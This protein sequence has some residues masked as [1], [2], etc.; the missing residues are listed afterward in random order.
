MTPQLPILSPVIYY[1]C[2]PFL[3]LETYLALS[4]STLFLRHTACRSQSRWKCGN[5][6]TQVTSPL[7]ISIVSNG[8]TRN[9][10]SPGSPRLPPLDLA[11]H[12]IA[13]LRVPWRR[14]RI[15]HLIV[16]LLPLLWIPPCIHLSQAVLGQFPLLLAHPTSALR[17]LY[18]LYYAA[19]LRTLRMME[20]GRLSQSFNRTLIKHSYRAKVR[21]YS[22]ARGPA[23]HDMQMHIIMMA[24]TKGAD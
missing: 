10:F 13:L 9:G 21:H 8:F 19:S 18:M 3:L 20:Y 14:R 17:N 12:R 16:W 7:P 1:D 5:I 11:S 23:P 15:L 24:T 2:C 6:H 4:S 22:V